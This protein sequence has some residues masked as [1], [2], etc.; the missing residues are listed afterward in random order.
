MKFFLL[1]LQNSCKKLLNNSKSGNKVT[2]EDAA[3]VAAEEQK[4]IK[5]L[6]EQQNQ[7]HKAESSQ[8][9]LHKCLDR[10]LSKSSAA[11]HHQ[12]LVEVHD[13]VSWRG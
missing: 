3:S 7:K 11:A 10:I 8:R 9:A 1:S 4:I 2:T 5:K 13:E 6:R 12:R